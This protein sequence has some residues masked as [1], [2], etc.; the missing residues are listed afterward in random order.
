MDFLDFL[1]VLARR[2]YV[3]VAGIFAM[4]LTAVAVIVWVPTQYQSSGQ[5]LLLLP[6]TASGKSTPTNPYLNLADGLTTTASLVSSQVS[7][8]E[9]HRQVVSRGYT[10]EYSVSVL[11]DAGPLIVVTATD[12]DP[13]KALRTR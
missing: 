9:T 1:R 12:S 13:A 10:G 7:S 5:L 3:V 4:V 2:W 8:K 6:P 11:P